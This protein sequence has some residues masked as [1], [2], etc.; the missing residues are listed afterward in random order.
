M[1]EYRL[2]HDDNAALEHY[3]EAVRSMQMLVIWPLASA[4]VWMLILAL[5]CGGVGG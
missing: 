4:I 2:D 5:L 1:S 3:K